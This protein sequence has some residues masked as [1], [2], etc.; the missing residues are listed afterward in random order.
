MSIHEG[1]TLITKIISNHVGYHR[2]HEAIQQRYRFH[3][4]IP[5]RALARDRFVKTVSLLYR[6]VKT[7]T[8]YCIFFKM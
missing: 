5:Q 8:N 2:F 4:A 6:F 3:K 1:L 7:V